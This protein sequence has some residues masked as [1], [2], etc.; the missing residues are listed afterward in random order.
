MNR[1]TERTDQ[2]DAGKSKLEPEA[3]TTSVGFRAI[4]PNGNTALPSGYTC[5]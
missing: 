3:G 5:A 1:S 2:L 4:R